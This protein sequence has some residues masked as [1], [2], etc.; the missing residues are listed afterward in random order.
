MGRDRAYLPLDG[1]S[2]PDAD[3]AKPCTALSMPKLALDDSLKRGDV[4]VTPCLCKHDSSVAAWESFYY[5]PVYQALKS[6]RDEM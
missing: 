3:T 6:I 4:Q 2:Y 5:D 1:P